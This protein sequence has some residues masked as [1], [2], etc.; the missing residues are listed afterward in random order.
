MK[1]YCPVLVWHGCTDSELTNGVQEGE[2]RFG[3]LLRSVIFS[4]DWTHFRYFLQSWLVSKTG[5]C[6]QSWDENY[7]SWDKRSFSRTDFEWH[8]KGR[9]SFLCS[10]I[11]DGFSDNSEKDIQIA[12]LCSF[13]YESL[14]SHNNLWT[15]MLSKWMCFNS[16]G[17]WM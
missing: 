14:K 5:P 4:S 16:S 8:Q 17:R 7:C 12:V 10:V 2:K 11:Y 13:D 3:F 1:A 15:E 9:K 6:N